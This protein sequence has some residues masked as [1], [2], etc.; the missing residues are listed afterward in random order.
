MNKRQMKKYIPRNTFYCYHEDGQPCRW[1]SIRHTKPNQVNGYCAYMRY[2]DWYDPW[3]NDL[4]DQCK[5]CNEYLYEMPLREL[6]EF[7]REH[8]IDIGEIKCI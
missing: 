3:I 1:W 7:A 4:W 8:N 5:L 6:R 2:G